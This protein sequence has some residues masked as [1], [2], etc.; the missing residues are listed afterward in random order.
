MATLVAPRHRAEGELLQAGGP[1]PLEVQRGKKAA[2]GW[3]TPEG[4]NVWLV[5]HEGIWMAVHASATHTNPAEATRRHFVFGS[6]EAD[7]TATVHRKWD[8]WDIEQATGWQGQQDWF[9]GTWHVEG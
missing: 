8:T 7:V 6:W 9:F 3:D 5:K 1:Q 4:H 2:I